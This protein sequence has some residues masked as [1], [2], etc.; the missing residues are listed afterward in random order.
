M[1]GHP[2]PQTQGI[3]WELLSLK[4]YS[5][6]WQ[7]HHFVFVSCES[8]VCVSVWQWTLGVL[9]NKDLPKESGLFGGERAL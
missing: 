4:G 6:I 3:G 5:L 2:R 1:C 9:G 8:V 7:F